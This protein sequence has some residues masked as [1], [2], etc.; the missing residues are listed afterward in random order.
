MYAIFQSSMGGSRKALSQLAL[1][2]RLHPTYAKVW[3]VDGLIASR[4]RGQL[5][6]AVHAWKQFL[7]LAPRAPVAAQV[8]VLLASAERALGQRQ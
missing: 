8:R 4:L 1:V 3:L 5:P 7:R 6:R 2:E